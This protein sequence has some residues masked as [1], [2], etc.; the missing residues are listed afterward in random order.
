M[1]LLLSSSSG[2]SGGRILFVSSNDFASSLVLS[3]LSC[4]SLIF[5]YPLP[6]IFRRY[7][8]AWSHKIFSP[9]SSSSS[10]GELSCPEPSTAAG[11]VTIGII[12]AGVLSVTNQMS[13]IG[14][15][16]GVVALCLTAVVVGD[17]A[18]EMVVLSVVVVA[19]VVDVVV[20][21]R[22]DL[23][24]TLMTGR[25]DCPCVLLGRIC[26]LRYCAD[27][28]LMVSGTGG[29]NWDFTDASL[30]SPVSKSEMCVTRRDD[31]HFYLSLLQWLPHA[32]QG[33]SI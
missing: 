3:S 23:L 32:W 17:R 11:V 29:R 10:M 20:V 8:I 27:N 22:G 19:V 18:V 15:F 21:D 25:S 24:F 31:E 9:S 6:R 16:F 12:S 5:I 28:C 1:R 26:A 14:L 2:S 33:S 7:I 13:S 4:C 30:F